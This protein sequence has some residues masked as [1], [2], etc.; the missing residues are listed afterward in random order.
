MILLRELRTKPQ[1]QKYFFP[2][3]FFL[4]W[5]NPGRVNNAVSRM[6]R[7]WLSILSAN[8][9]VHDPLYPSWLPGFLI[10]ILSQ[11]KMESCWDTNEKT[12]RVCHAQK[13]PFFLTDYPFPNF[14]PP[15]WTTGIS[16]IFTKHMWLYSAEIMSLHSTVQRNKCKCSG[17]L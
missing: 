10:T 8:Y 17:L 2:P 13:G 6:S 5:L 12:H 14:W 1:G 9:G 3:F 16:Y 7:H 15:P 4:T 11:Q